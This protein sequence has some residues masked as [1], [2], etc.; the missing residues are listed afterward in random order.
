MA[1]S[2]LGL[3]LNKDLST[4]RPDGRQECS[5]ARLNDLAALTIAFGYFCGHHAPCSMS[6]SSPPIAGTS[7]LFVVD[8]ISRA[9]ESPERGTSFVIRIHARADRSI[10]LAFDERGRLV[11]EEA[12][13]GASEGSPVGP[14]S[15]VAVRG[16]F[17]APD[18][19][20]P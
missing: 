7:D 15:G 18:A 16:T 14:S 13:I 9:F 2:A 8:G 6:G 11:A 4:E 5:L 19:A 3:R 20:D 1:G 10:E 17:D 12:A